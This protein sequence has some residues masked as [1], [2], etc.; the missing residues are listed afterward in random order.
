MTDVKPTPG[1]MYVRGHGNRAQV[2]YGHGF[3]MS[4]PIIPVNE[5]R[6]DGE[7][8]LAMRIRTGGDRLLAAAEAEANARLTAAAFTSYQKHCA[9]PVAAAEG[10]LL[11]EALIL[12]GAANCPQCDGSGTCVASGRGGDPEPYQC[13]WCYRTRALLAKA[14]VA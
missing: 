2:F 11:G 13:E 8:W 7:S 10:D 3:Y 14:A 1:G 5:D 12:L 6:A 4:A 9:D